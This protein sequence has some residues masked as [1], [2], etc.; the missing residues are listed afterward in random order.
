MSRV[1]FSSG[2][3]NGKTERST[4]GTTEYQPSVIGCARRLN[5][6][7]RLT[8]LAQAARNSPTV[9]CNRRVRAWRSAPACQTGRGGHATLFAY[10][11]IQSIKWW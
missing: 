11:H 8:L 10:R 5:S 4:Q 1:P 3:E 2:Q 7:V 9:M 6:V